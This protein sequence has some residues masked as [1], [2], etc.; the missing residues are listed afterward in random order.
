[1]R[2]I[3]TIFGFL[4]VLLLFGFSSVASVYALEQNDGGQS[5]IESVSTP[6][7][8]ITK[9]LDNWLIDSDDKSATAEFL[10]NGGYQG[11]PAIKIVKESV[12]SWISFVARTTVQS[13]PAGKVML[14]SAWV[15]V[16]KGGVSLSVKNA[17]NGQRV[18]AGVGNALSIESKQWVKLLARVDCSDPN[19]KF[20][21]AFVAG[22]KDA[23][24]SEFYVTAPTVEISAPT[25]R[26]S[27]PPVEGYFTHRIDENLDRA[28]I[29]IPNVEDESNP[30]NASSQSNALQSNASHGFYL[31]WR[32]LQQD[33]PNIGFNVYRKSASSDEPW[34]KLNDKPIVQTTDFV[35]SHAS[36][37]KSW[38]WKIVPVEGKTGEE[39]ESRAEFARCADFSNGI[40]IKFRDPQT[41]PCRLAI[42]DLDGDSRYDYLI[43]KPNYNVDPYHMPGY[44]KKSLE[45][46]KLEAYNADGKFLWEYDF[47]WSIETGIWYSPFIAADLDGDG[48]AEVIAKTSE[49]DFRNE[50]G[51]VDAGPEYLTV[52]NGETGK[53]ITRVDWPS[54]DGFLYNYASRNMLSVAY[55]DG[56]TP[57]VIVLRGTYSLQKLAAYQFRSGKLEPKLTWTN[58]FEPLNVWGKG[59]HTLHSVDVDRDGRDEIAVGSFMLDDNGTIRWALGLAHPDHMYIGD[60]IPSRPGL[61]I[62]NGIEGRVDKNG[63]SVVDADTGEIVWGI[64]ER[65]YHIHGQGLCADIDPNSPG[66]ECFGGES[67]NDFTEDRFLWSAE[68]KL[69]QRSAPAAKLKEKNPQLNIEKE[70]PMTNI[71]RWGLSMKSVYWDADNLKEF[72]QP[73]R[74]LYKYSTAENLNPRVVGSLLKVADIYGDWRE[75]IITTVPGELRIYSTR[76]PAK[77]RRPCLMQDRNYRA[78]ILESSM[79]YG[80]SPLLGR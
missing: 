77:T 25:P 38:N 41:Q 51:R 60:I 66:Y 43:L 22:Q 72:W 7:F 42:A 52:F 55:L 2:L 71:A 49:G 28:L 75:E 4:P 46:P 56:K 12:G 17:K 21:P 30:I 79:G 15:R 50:T 53:E 68:G 9:T 31:S 16:E 44:W 73:N 14:F 57:F 58:A 48:K 74:L 69:L 32:L 19:Q 11:L 1:M 67:K 70:I 61:E 27:R 3:R 63:M 23:G 6:E 65:T 47:G 35:D 13:A 29:A 33:E 76:I 36:Q 5:P 10:P 40:T 62:Y 8:A 34:I 78:S 37:E 39:S 59:A 26:D 64:Q 24:P 18:S 54:R 45:T 20:F 80:Q